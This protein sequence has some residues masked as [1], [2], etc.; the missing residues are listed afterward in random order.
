MTTHGHDAAIHELAPTG[1][2]RAGIAI[3]P[4]ASASWATRD[5]A[6]GEPR[7]VAVELAVALARD[8]DRPLGLVAF[9]SSG[10]VTDALGGERIDVGFLPVDDERKTRVA[11]GPDYALGVST[12]LVPPGSAIASAAEVDRPGVRVVGVEDT[13]TI[14]AA[15]RSLRRAQVRG[16]RSADELL[17]L[18]LAG[19]ADAVALGS[20]S[21]LELADRVPGSRL[22]EDHFW[23][24]GTAVAI[25]RNRP[26]ALMFVTDFIER[27]KADG[28]VQ[29]AF[30]AAGLRGAKLAPQGS[31][32]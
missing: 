25:P 2:L 22:L 5:P 1:L 6:T 31:W 7:G 8:A 26:A 27:A 32:S 24:T 13:A 19:E 14:R 23:E 21:L 20:D 4:A 12:Y 3:G 29:A 11:F 9:T 30:D 10:H 28:T 15:R 17:R 16:T 18:L